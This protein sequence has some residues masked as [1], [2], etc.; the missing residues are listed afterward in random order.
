M[1]VKVRIADSPPKVL[2]AHVRW[3]I[4]RDVPEVLAIENQSFEFPWNEESFIRALRQ[5]NCIGMVAEAAEKV[6]GYMIYELHQ[7]R[8]HLLNFAVHQDCRFKGVGRQMIKKL[9]DKLSRDRR[10][11]IMLE[12]RERNLDAQLFFRRMGFRAV[13]VLRGYYEDS[14]EDAYL[15]QFRYALESQA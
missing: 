5:R 12:V 4:R 8:L 10:S 3:M 9:T 15:M 14:S 7:S 2:Q 13:S 1:N 6:A 11:R